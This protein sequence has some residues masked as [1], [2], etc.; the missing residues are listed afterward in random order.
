MERAGDRAGSRRQ[1]PRTQ[2]LPAH[3][4]MTDLLDTGTQ[5]EHDGR[6]H[7][8]CRVAPGSLVFARLTLAR[9]GHERAKSRLA[10][11]PFAVVSNSRCQTACVSS[12]PQRVA[13]PGLV[14]IPSH[15]T[16]EG[17]AERRQAHYFICR[18]CETR[19]S[20]RVRRGA[21]H[22]AGRSPLGAPP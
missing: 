12:F 17:W 1:A 8:F 6:F 4:I 15:P 11:E 10:Q 20:A 2:R 14:S 16:E 9:P 3:P 7:R 5:R 13:A 19:R 18:V 22:D 21:S